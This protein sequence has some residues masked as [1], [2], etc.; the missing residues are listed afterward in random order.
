MAHS[1]R[2]SDQRYTIIFST[3]W[4]SICFD[5]VSNLRRTRTNFKNATRRH[6]T[7]NL[8]LLWLHSCQPSHL[9]LRP[10][11]FIKSR[12]YIDEYRKLDNTS[13]VDDIRYFLIQ[14]TIQMVLS[15]C[16]YITD[17]INYNF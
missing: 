6:W 4:I 3:D 7:L 12:C 11:I 9:Y 8:V 15:V 16:I 13:L 5:R 14:R 10:N 17:T 2:I 1:S